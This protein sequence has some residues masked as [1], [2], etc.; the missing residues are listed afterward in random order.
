MA[1]RMVPKTKLPCS[2]WAVATSKWQFGTCY[3]GIWMN[4]YN[5]PRKQF[6]VLEPCS[7]QVAIIQFGIARYW[8]LDVSQE[9]QVVFLTLINVQK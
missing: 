7:K 4:P 2:K 3:L 9:S 5:V 1:K 6:L 8:Y